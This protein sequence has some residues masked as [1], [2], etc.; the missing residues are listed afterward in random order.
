MLPCSSTCWTRSFQRWKGPSENKLIDMAFNKGR[1][2][3]RKS[4][5]NKY[6]AGAPQLQALQLQEIGII[7]IQLNTPAPLQEGTFLD[8]SKTAVSYEDFVSR[9]ISF[10]PVFSHNC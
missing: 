2:D 8:H 3:D 9:L 10:L 6:Q 5:M 1:S 4:W 7:G